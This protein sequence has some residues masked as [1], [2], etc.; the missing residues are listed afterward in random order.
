MTVKVGINGFGRIGRITFRALAIRSDEFDVVAIDDL[1]EPN[2]LVMLKYDRLRFIRNVS[3]KVSARRVPLRCWIADNRFFQYVRKVACWGVAL[4]G[5]ESN[6]ESLIAASNQLEFA[7][8]SYCES[9][10]GGIP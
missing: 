1:A 2:D 10:F 8:P 6:S 4:Q 3:S 9:Q 5:A 7:Q